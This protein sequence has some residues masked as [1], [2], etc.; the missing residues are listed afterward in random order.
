MSK[1]E[2]LGILLAKAD[3]LHKQMNQLFLK[4]GLDTPDLTQLSYSDR[5]EWYYIYE[6]SKKVADE[7]CNLIN[8][9]L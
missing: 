2:R 6:Q 1:G 7:I 8:S 4:S 5:E 3:V 9:K